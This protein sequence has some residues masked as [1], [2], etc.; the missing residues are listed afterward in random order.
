[1]PRPSSEATRVTMAPTGC[2][3][4]E[5]SATAMSGAI[6]VADRGRGGAH[7]NVDVGGEPLAEG[8]TDADD[9]DEHENHQES[10]HCGVAPRDGLASTTHVKQH[11][12]ASVK[13]LYTPTQGGGWG[14]RA[15]P[16]YKG[17][18]PRF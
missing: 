15:R 16:P 3:R 14:V 9:E 13:P 2:A 7:V 17:R 8:E 11:Y 10:F 12:R 6:S 1:M 4:T 18:A 5:A